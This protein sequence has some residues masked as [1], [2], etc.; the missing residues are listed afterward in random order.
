ML[1]KNGRYLIKK[2]CKK[3]VG[4]CLF[5]IVLM[6]GLTFIMGSYYG[7]SVYVKLD[8]IT[9]ELGDK[10]PDDVVN[11]MN[12]LANVSNLS[13]ENN[14]PKDEDGN[15]NMIGKFSYYLVYNDN[16]YK[17][18]KLTNVRATIT[19][20]DTV[21]PVINIKNNKKFKYNSSIKAS[22]IATCKDLS[23]CKLY[24]K[25]DIDTSKSGNY[26][27]NIIAVD[28]GNNKSYATT[29]ITVLEKPKPKYY[30][31]SFTKLDNN[32]NN[33]NK[34]LSTEEKNN[35]RYQVVEYAKRFIGNPYVYGGTSLTNGTDCSGFTMGVYA[36]FGY[37]LPRVSTS[38]GYIGKQISKS[39]LLPGD[40]VVYHYASGGGHV[41]IYAGNG[42]M[43]HAGTSKTGIVLAPVFSG[44]KTY[45]RI[46][47]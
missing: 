41:G 46:I 45:R 20:E 17:F 16:T 12:I 6:I 30:S 14:V 29:K 25:E 27:V 40:L 43:V 4:I 36:Y 23:G 21:A 38:Q 18:S 13:F 8:S 9:V 19:V 24:L 35:L 47:Y 2:N 26:E 11:Y 44:N 33:L 28:G 31:S 37:N 15:T 22:D 32:N 5:P 42:M 3:I 7:S 1:M 10:L 34:K 39:E